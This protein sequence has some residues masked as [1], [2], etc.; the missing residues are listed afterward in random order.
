MIVTFVIFVCFLRVFVGVAV[1]TSIHTAVIGADIPVFDTV[2]ARSCSL[3][4]QFFEPDAVGISQNIESNTARGM[5][6]IM[7]VIPIC[8]AGL[9]NNTMLFG[10]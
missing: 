1:F 8:F 3:M 7:A 2:A 6:S 9:K 5:D 10:D 4:F